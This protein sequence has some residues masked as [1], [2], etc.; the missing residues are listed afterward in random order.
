MISRPRWPSMDC[1]CNGIRNLWNER[2]PESSDL[3]EPT[4]IWIQS[5]SSMFYPK[6][7]FYMSL[8]QG[9]M[10]FHTPADLNCHM[11]DINSALRKELNEANEKLEL[12]IEIHTI[13][14]KRWQAIVDGKKICEMCKK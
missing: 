11:Y 4:T 6:A 2:E 8:N 5:K 12:M 3:A 10:K 14:H 1:D 9:W 7:L 13:H